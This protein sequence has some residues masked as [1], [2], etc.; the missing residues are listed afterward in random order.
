MP[1]VEQLLGQVD[2]RHA[3]GAVARARE[4]HEQRGNVALQ[5]QVGSGH[6]IRG[7]DRIDASPKLTRQGRREA[8]ADERGGSGT[9]E[10]DAQRRI[11][12]QRPEI[13]TEAGLLAL[14]QPRD[15]L[16]HDGLLGDL[17]RR[18]G[19]TTLRQLGVAAAGEHL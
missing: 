14:Q 4:G 6:Q 5:M 7:R 19:S 2:G 11:R 17:S 12:E 10:H 18:A 15:L 8:L 9:G 16:P 3:F 13:P 1:L